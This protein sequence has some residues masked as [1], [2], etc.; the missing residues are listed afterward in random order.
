MNSRSENIHVLDER[1]DPSV[2]IIADDN[3]LYTSI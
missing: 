1:N 2:H 3:A